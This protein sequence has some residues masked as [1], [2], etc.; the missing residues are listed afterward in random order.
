[1]ASTTYEITG[2]DITEVLEWAATM[3]EHAAPHGDETTFVVYLSHADGDRVTLIRLAGTDPTEV[4][5]SAPFGGDISD[6]T[7][8][9]AVEAG[10]TA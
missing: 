6:E 1:M 10:S 4:G 3:A 8:G 5:E 9:G 7:P 2:A